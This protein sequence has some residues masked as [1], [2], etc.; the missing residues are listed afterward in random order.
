[1]DSQTNK[2]RRPR[3]GFILLFF[4]V[5]GWS[6]FYHQEQRVDTE[7]AKCEALQEQREAEHEAKLKEFRWGRQDC[8]QYLEAA[9]SLAKMV[10]Y[11]YTVLSADEGRAHFKVR[12]ESADLAAQV[13][14]L[15]RQSHQ[16]EGVPSLK[17]SYSALNKLLTSLAVE[18]RLQNNSAE[19]E[20][21]ALLRTRLVKRVIVG[22]NQSFST[23]S[24]QLQ[25]LLYDLEALPR[26]G[27]DLCKELVSIKPALKAAFAY[28]RDQQIAQHLSRF[29]APYRWEWSLRGSFPREQRKAVER[30]LKVGYDL[31]VKEKKLEHLKLYLAG[32]EDH[33]PGHATATKLGDRITAIVTARVAVA[34]E[35]N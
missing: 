32:S 16:A 29:E 2:S 27:E 23:K 4:T 11:E 28:A 6:H 19:A 5:L 17:G 22:S 26:P 24:W 3:L 31:P 10:H 20:K 14:E 8:G 7:I 9:N 25:G 21:L 1:M 13:M 33:W 34:P 15:I 30:G 18:A 35:L 12:P